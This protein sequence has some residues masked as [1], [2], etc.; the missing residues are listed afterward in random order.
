MDGLQDDALTP[1]MLEWR[2]RHYVDA[3]R[4][5]GVGS[6]EMDVETGRVWCSD[7]LYRMFNLEPGTINSV[8]DF[9]ASRPPERRAVFMAAL[10]EWL[11]TGVPIG[12]DAP[13]SRPD[14]REAWN[15][16][17][18]MS[19]L[20]EAGRPQRLIGTVEDITELKLAQDEIARKT[21]ALEAANAALLEQTA[22]LTAQSDELRRLNSMKDEFLSL[23]SHELRTPLTT[24]QGML[25]VLER[26]DARRPD[27]DIEACHRRLGIATQTLTSLVNDLLSAAQLQA[28]HFTLARRPFEPAELLT[29]ALD[30]VAALAEAKGVSLH[31]R[32]GDGLGEWHGDRHRLAQVL[33]NL[34][35]NAIRH[36]PEGGEVYLMAQREADQLV[37]SVADTGDGLSE[38]ARACLFERFA[39]HGAEDGVGLGLFVVKALVEAHG[40]QVS[41]V[42][43]PDAGTTFTLSLPLS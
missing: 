3:Q 25:G 38:S 15:R 24:I 10:A 13:T 40:G 22:L 41:V 4:A 11:R 7:E 36:T 31:G 5:S 28:G 14:G 12:Y 37:I 32:S 1:S 35:L 18:G 43:A 23:L 26:H 21:A 34:L 27:P 29:D 30:E 2:Y 16:S 6:W 42:S 33:R 20:G 8:E 17:K 9:V 19:L 39:T